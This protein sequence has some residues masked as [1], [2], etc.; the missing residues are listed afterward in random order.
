MTKSKRYWPLLLVRETAATLVPSLV[1]TTCAP[2]M[3]ACVES[4]TSPCTRARTSCEDAGTTDKNRNAAAERNLFIRYPRTNKYAVAVYNN[5]GSSD[6]RMCCRSQ[7]HLLHT[8]PSA[9]YPCDLPFA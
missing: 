9:A 2:T 8:A 3:M 6:R 1:R 5:V 4:V 7:H